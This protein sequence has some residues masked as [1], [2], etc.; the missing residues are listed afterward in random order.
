MESNSSCA[1]NCCNIEEVEKWN[2]N[3]INKFGLTIPSQP[4]RP[5]SIC[6]NHC[7]SKS[8]ISCSRFRTEQIPDYVKS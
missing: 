8:V 5:C 7:R 3:Y 2:P 1:A 6:S 4:E